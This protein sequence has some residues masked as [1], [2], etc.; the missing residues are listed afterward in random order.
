MTL[1][2]LIQKGGLVRVA[3]ATSATS[4]TQVP[5]RAGTVATVATVAVAIPTTPEITTARCWQV[6]YPGLDRVEVIFA[7]EASPAEVAAIYPGASIEPLPDPPPR[8]ATPA[9]ADELRALIGVVLANGSADDRT[10]ALAV[11]CA[12]PDAARTS[13][14]ALVADLQ[15][16]TPL[17]SDDRR[18]CRQCSKLTAAG[19]CLA[20]ARGD[21]PFAAS[22]K[23][24]PVPDVLKRC[25]G[26]RPLVDDPDQHPGAERW[27]GLGADAA[28]LRGTSE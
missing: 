13:F 19:R 4:A 15:R 7:P 28:Q 18:T 22:R 17:V 21:L 2:A 24:A 16:D 8:E 23:Y 26:F 27:R 6:Q 3:T 11:A 25:E 12:D 10:E 14:R 9:E 5:L 20:A 1:A